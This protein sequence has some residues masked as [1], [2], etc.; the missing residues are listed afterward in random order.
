MFLY[1]VWATLS[2]MWADARN[3]A[4]RYGILQ[5]LFVLILIYI[6]SRLTMHQIIRAFFWAFVFMGVQVFMEIPIIDSHSMPAGFGEKNMLGSRMFFLF[7]ACLYMIYSRRAVLVEKGLAI[8]CAPLA[9]FVIVLAESATSLVLSVLSLF[10]LTVVA[11][12]WQAVIKVRALSTLMMMF[13]GV[14]ILL[15]TL[16][17]FSL[18]SQGPVNA[19]LDAVGKDATLTGRTELWRAAQ[20]QFVKKPWLGVGA[21]SYWLINRGE[22]QTWM[23]YFSKNIDESFSFHNSY[24]EILVHLGVVGL[25]CFLVGQIYVVYQILTNWFR[26]QDLTNS[27]FFLIGMLLLARSMTEPDFYV[28]FDISRMLL[29]LGGMS[30]VSHR[31]VWLPT[32]GHGFRPEPIAEGQA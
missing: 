18:F 15:M 25:V 27:F 12:I 10:V 19:F 7:T 8:A 11:L 31:L 29:F 28:S 26:K 6:S 32:R 23:E 30:C 3:D 20:E 4:F 22:A 5:T 13:I 17:S 14:L 21:E 2:F 24:W 9:F 1:P 16:I